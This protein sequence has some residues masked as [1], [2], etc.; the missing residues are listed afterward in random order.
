MLF[1]KFKSMGPLIN[2]VLAVII[3]CKTP[4]TLMFK[5][6]KRHLKSDT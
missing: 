6:P 1:T 4:N 2:L 3:T 5:T